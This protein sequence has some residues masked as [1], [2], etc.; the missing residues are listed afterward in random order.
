[1]S[2]RVYLGWDSREIDAFQVAAK[3]Y[4]SFGCEVI[5]LHEDRLRL[6]GILTRPL[7]RRGRMFD[8]NSAAEQSTDFAISRFAVP[9]LAHSGWALFAD[10]DTMA[11]QDPHLLLSIADDRFAVMVVKRA[12]QQMEGIKMD[13]QKQVAYH[14]KNWSSVALWNASHPALARMNLTTLNQWPGRDLHAF[15]F[16]ADDEI[17]CLPSAWNHLVGVDPP[18]SDPAIIHWTNGTP[19]LPGYEESEHAQVW[20]EASQR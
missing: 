1:M 19:N 14:R 15:K 16:L 8:F 12:T 7:D 9:M 13:G 17:G 5:A 18:R 2:L 10:A 6:C 3:S 4:A 20:R 11:R